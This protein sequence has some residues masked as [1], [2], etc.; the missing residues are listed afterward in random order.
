MA[1]KIALIDC[2]QAG[3]AGDMLMSCL[4]DA[5]AS[6]NKVINAIFAC[7]DFL[8][9]SKILKASFTKTTS[10]GFAATQLQMTYK[11]SVHERKGVD[12]YRSLAACCESLDLAQQAKV[13]ALE[14]LKTIISAETIIHGERFQNVHLHEASS[15]DTLV[16]LVGCAVALQDLNLFDSRIFSTKVAVGGGQLRFS[17][18]IVP[19]PASAILE[20]FKGKQFVLIGGPIEEE[21]TTP[22]GAAMLVNL[23][24]G[25]TNYYPS[26]LP[27]RIGYGAGT[28]KFTEFANVVRLIIG[29]SSTFAETIKDS[30]YVVETNIDDISGELI[31]N[32]IEQL[33]DVS[34]DVTVIPAITKKNR[35]AYLIRI[36]TH[37]TQLN[38][39]LE[40]LFNESGTLGARVQEVERFVLQRTVLTFPIN[41][42]DNIF[43]VR[44]KIAKDPNGRVLNIKPEFEDIKIIASRCKI[45]IKRAN[46]LVNEKVLQNAKENTQ[47]R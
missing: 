21:L 25:S 38:N 10:H 33:T 44:V 9:G 43:N 24:Q 13:F 20:I 23:A 46:E 4:V 30:I 14:S 15:I 39:V 36:I 1:A 5:G 12:L 16:D 45:S 6:K 8:K 11:D 2:Q 31:G 19:N 17:H 3:I 18:G 29:T 27:Q 42:K 34:K 35:P 37:Y 7:Q 32:L 47:N 40:T 28:K 22:T 41:I 26:I